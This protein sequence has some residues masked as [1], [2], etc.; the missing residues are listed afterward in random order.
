MKKWGG[1]A[2]ARL[3]GW[4]ALLAMAGG[5]R[6]EASYPE[7]PIHVVVPFSA[8]SAVDLLPRIVGEKLAAKWGQPVIVENRPGA[9]GNIGAAAVARAD[10]NGYTLLATPPPPLVINQ[11]LYATLPYDP[12]AFTPV[13]VIAAVP[14]A[15]VV[16]PAV[17]VST[18]EGLLEY[19]KRH[20]DELNFASPGAGTT[21]HLTG[22]WF[23]TLAGVRLVH[24]AYKGGAPA[25]SDLL[26]GQVQV[27]F[28][29]LGDVMPHVRSGRLRLLAVGSAQRDPALP[30]VPALSERLPGLVSVAWY[31]LVAPPKTPPE[32]AAKLAAGVHAALQLPD[33]VAALRDLNATPIGGSPAATAAFLKDEEQRWRAVVT[34]AGVR[35]E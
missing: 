17:P 19:A 30:E 9:S 28:A 31:A 16:H 18:L 20:P 4:T 7:R 29:N 22:E 3:A 8:G 10:P 1:I 15:L 2:Y 13:T 34:A 23:K 12:R 35:P 24:V 14:N 27:M 33:I 5:V 25:L 32:I 21:P 26:G 11:H 6:G